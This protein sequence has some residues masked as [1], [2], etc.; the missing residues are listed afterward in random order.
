MAPTEGWV[1]RPE[2]QWGGLPPWYS[3]ELS[4]RKTNWNEWMNGKVSGIGCNG[5]TAIERHVCWYQ[6]FSSSAIYSYAHNIA[7]KCGKHNFHFNTIHHVP[8]TH[9]TKQLLKPWK[10]KVKI[11]KVHTQTPK[12]TITRTCIY[13]SVS[14]NQEQRGRNELK[15]IKSL[16][17]LQRHHIRSIEL[18]NETPTMLIESINQYDKSIANANIYTY[19]HG[20]SSAKLQHLRGEKC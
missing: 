14:I 9:A 5:I 3:L 12:I 2:W 15:Q 8:T 4:G 10:R 19:T 13:Y 20:L 16:K 6:I 17:E 18:C 7:F 11:H 1:A